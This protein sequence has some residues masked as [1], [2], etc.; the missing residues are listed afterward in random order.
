MAKYKNEDYSQ[1]QLIAASLEEQL[2]LGTLEFAIHTLMD[3]YNPALNV[4]TS[5]SNTAP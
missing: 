2:M 1:K 4:E 5:D 3:T